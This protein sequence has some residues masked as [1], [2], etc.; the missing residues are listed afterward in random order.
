MLS[1]SRIDFTSIEYRA[2]KCHAKE[3][4]GFPVPMEVTKAER[5]FTQAKCKKNTANNPIAPRSHLAEHKL[6]K[7]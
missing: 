4:C 5:T 3:S 6:L 1:L 2:C 7:K